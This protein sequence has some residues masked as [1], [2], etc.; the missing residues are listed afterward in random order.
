MNIAN[1]SM[2]LAQSSSLSDVGTAVLSKSLDT[3]EQN[4]NSLLKMVDSA[5]LERSVN[6]SIGSNF[7]MVV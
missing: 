7:D 1:I 3:A 6:P 2:A 5:A 4:G